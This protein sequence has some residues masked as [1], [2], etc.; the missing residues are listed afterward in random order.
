MRSWKT[1]DGSYG[2]VGD[3]YLCRFF[4]PERRA[5]AWPGGLAAVRFDYSVLLFPDSVFINSYS[6]SSSKVT[7][8]IAF[9]PDD[10]SAT[11]PK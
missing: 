10:Y 7:W 3:D 6:G 11:A 9:A 5:T 4:Q 1:T 2:S 8:A